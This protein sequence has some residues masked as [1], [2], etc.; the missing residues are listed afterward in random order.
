MKK[1][2]AESKR[3]KRAYSSYSTQEALRELKRKQKVCQEPNMN[4]LARELSY[5]KKYGAD[6]KELLKISDSSVADGP[7]CVCP[8][9]Q[10]TWFKHSVIQVSEMR[11]TKDD[12]QA[13][14]EKC[15]MNYVSENE[16]EW[17]CKTCRTAISEARIPKLSVYNKMAFPEQPPE[18]KLFVM[19]KRLIAQRI[20]FMQIRSYPIGFKH[21]FEVTL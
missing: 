9:C 10:Q 14:F 1:Q 16:K 2:E 5:R 15:T 4:I 7:V 11:L 3:Y 19:D 18:L 21:L 12:E 6:M 20:P 13:V 8:I 17:I